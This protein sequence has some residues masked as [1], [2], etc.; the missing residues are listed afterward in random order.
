MSNS[1][2]VFPGVQAEPTD[3]YECTALRHL[4]SRF[5]TL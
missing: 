3:F 4:E 2:V 5:A 1:D